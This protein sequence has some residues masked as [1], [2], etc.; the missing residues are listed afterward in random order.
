VLTIY[1]CETK[2]TDDI[3]QIINEFFSKLKF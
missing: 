1:E 3:K 2:D